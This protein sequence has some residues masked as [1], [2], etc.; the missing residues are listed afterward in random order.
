MNILTTLNLSPSQTPALPAN[1]RSRLVNFLIR[2]EHSDAALA[3]LSVLQR[4]RP[5]LVSLYDAHARALLAQDQIDEA[6]DVMTARHA[7]KQSLTSQVLEARLHLARGDHGAAL[8]IAKKLVVEERDSPL[9]WGLLGDVHLEQGNLDAAEGAY[10]RIDEIRPGSRLHAHSLARL[11]HTQGDYVSASAWAV[12]LESSADE[13][14]PLDVPR[15]RWLRDYYRE[16]GETN[17]AADIDAELQRR[18]QTELHDLQ[19]ALANMLGTEKE[20]KGP[21]EPEEPKG[22]EITTPSVPFGSSGPSG[23]SVEITPEER[24]QLESATKNHFGFTSLLPGQAEVMS[25][26]L[27][28]EDTLAVMPTGGGKSLCYQLPALL[29]EGTTLVVS[30][31]IALMKDQVDSLPPE[32]RRRA[33]TINSTLAGDELRRRMN[34]ATQGHYR[35]IYAAPERLRQPPFLYALR[36][37][38]LS[39][40]VIDEAHCVS[41]WGHDFRPDYLFL[42]EARR[43]LGD[44]PIL[45]M[46]ATAPPRVRGD[47]MR[48][49]GDLELV[50][51]DVH[52]PNLRLEAIA[53]PN[54]DAKLGHLIA[55]CQKTEGA[56]IVYAHSRAKCEELAAVL[57]ARGIAAGHYHAGIDDRAAAQDRFMQGDMR[58]VVATVAFGMGIDK[59]DIRFI[60]HYHLP[61]SLEAYYQEAGRA[62][63]DGLHSRCVLFYAPSD[64][65]N[66]TRWARQDQMPVD[67][68][69]QVYR[70]VDRRLGDAPVGRMATDDLM[71][72]VQADDT[73][74]RVALSLLEEAGLLR[75][76]FDAPR[77]AMI[78]LRTAAGDDPTLA[79]FAEVARLVRGQ[80]VP[81]DVVDLAL[82]A[83]LDPTDI[84]FQLLSWQ[85]QDRLGYRPAGRDLLLERLSPP[86]DSAQRVDSLLETYAAIQGQRIDE[87]VAYAKTRRCRHGHISAYFGGRVIERCDACDNCL[88]L[89]TA[90]IP[91]RDGDERQ[92]FGALLR[93]VE[94]LKWS[95][96]R[97]NLS[98]ILKGSPRAP[99]GSAGASHHGALA[100][101][102]ASAIERLVDRL[103]D[104]GLL[105]TRQLDHGGV[106]VEMSAA[107]RDA[108]AN[109]KKLDALVAPLAQA[110]E[111]TPSKPRERSLDEPTEP[112]DEALFQRLRQ[113]RLAK[114]NAAEVPPYVVAHDATLRQVAALK[115]QT[116][117][118]LEAVRGMGPKKL[119]DY[120]EA[121]LEVVRDYLPGK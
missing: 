61:R 95:Y 12:R 94:S 13:E 52:R 59:P 28:G 58:V 39:R 77:K 84:E 103:I 45:A 55:L 96:G 105:Q 117:L 73:Q 36:Q 119:A 78:T 48:R 41:L 109:P 83:G 76:H 63:R 115:P 106:V 67:F 101:R 34:R 85:S 107:G 6:L 98:L 104:A 40:F 20:P 21:K 116:L 29:T 64:R 113:W 10:R 71:R 90:A 49:L 47:I 88:G 24:E 31:L 99:A 9:A 53:T 26:M 92:E 97:R 111:S 5:D 3:C 18:H 112:V 14:T 8:A 42:A 51:T 22:P 72:D 62:G 89:R 37:A 91:Q 17:R 74:V 60:V 33:T 79:A 25:L 54:E 35:L 68:L 57:R 93:C 75:R 80:T 16:S 46:T 1:L 86:A 23:S 114:A 81:R 32:I 121:I 108:I 70:A 30:P 69:R 2:W 87:I 44:P 100:H 120:G 43:A 7:R 19:E 66:L 50:A 56:G 15:L 38:G 82:A 4:Y 11:Y 102:S 118:E 110:A 65:A 27:R